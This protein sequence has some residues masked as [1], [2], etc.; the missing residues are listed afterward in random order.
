MDTEGHDL[1]CH[2]DQAGDHGHQTYP[3]VEA[4]PIATRLYPSQLL[5]VACSQ[6]RAAHCVGVLSPDRDYPTGSIFGSKTTGGGVL[7]SL[8]CARP[9]RIRHPRPQ[10]R[11]E[12]RETRRDQNP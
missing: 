11:P 2:F 9:T 3:L 5:S 1:P 10:L 12:A 4:H 6:A 8:A 7:T